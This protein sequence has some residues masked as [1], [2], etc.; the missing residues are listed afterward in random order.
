VTALTKTN[1]TGLWSNYNLTTTG[2][3]TASADINPKPVSVT[4]N[5]FI[6]KLRDPDPEFTFD[7]T[8]YSAEYLA[9]LIF[10]R[11]PGES[12]GVYRITLLN[13]NFNVTFVGD[14][15]LEIEA[16]PAKP[17]GELVN[18]VTKTTDTKISSTFSM[19]S[20]ALNS[21]SRISSTGVKVELVKRP[22]LQES[23]VVAVS[24]P[25]NTSAA[26]AGLSFALPNELMSSI[27]NAVNVEA[28]LTNG[29]P[30]PSWLRFDNT[31]GQ[32]VVSEVA[33]VSFP[34]EL[35]VQLGNQQ[36]LVVI[37]ERQD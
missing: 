6:K 10:T 34:L 5:R 7:S 11:E 16:S 31:N 24:L 14:A 26:G 22:E 33:D 28:R 18:D 2:A 32:F 23:G 19:A 27:A 37:S 30:L 15:V 35:S 36:V 21:A 4:F 13:P 17:T 12:P 29:D 3:M 8:G 9:Q 1:G 25:A 20:L